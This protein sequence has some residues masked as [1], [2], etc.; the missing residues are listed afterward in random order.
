PNPLLTPHAAAELEHLSLQLADAPLQA[1]AHLVL[2]LVQRSVVGVGI[3][4]GAGIATAAGIGIAVLPLHAPPALLAQLAQQPL[5][6]RLR[7]RQTAPQRRELLVRRL[8]LLLRAQLMPRL[9]VALQDLQRRELLLRRRQLA[10]RGRRAGAR[11]L[12]RLLRR[13]E[14]RR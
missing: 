4:T 13:R 7:G 2:E 3:G 12:Q 8:A 14:L 9:R 5:V 6:L 11:L 1:R 10:L